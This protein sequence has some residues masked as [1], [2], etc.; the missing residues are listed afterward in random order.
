MSGIDRQGR[1]IPTP[2]EDVVGGGGAGR[3]GRLPALAV[4][5]KTAKVS[6]TTAKVR[7][8]FAV[9]VIFIQAHLM[10]ELL[11]V[12]RQKKFFPDPKQA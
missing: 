3:L 6:V 7:R 2:L 11:G 10:E 12:N 4:P 8:S 9:V 1:L 5:L